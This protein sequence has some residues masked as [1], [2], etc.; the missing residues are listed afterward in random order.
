MEASGRHGLLNVQ[1]EIRDAHED[2][3]DGRD[4]PGARTTELLKK[5]FGAQQ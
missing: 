5:V 3:G 4:D 2:V 1:P